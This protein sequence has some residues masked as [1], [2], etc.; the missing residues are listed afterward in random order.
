M[1]DT[2]VG[3]ITHYFDRIGVAVIELAA[4]LKTGDR[5]KIVGHDQEFE[6]TVGS[7]QIEHQ[8]IPEA[9]KGNAIGMKV[10]Q[11]VKEGDQVFKIE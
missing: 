10:D 1:A 9:K 4:T 3:K 7:M 8:D 6:Q 5:I 2:L 11:P